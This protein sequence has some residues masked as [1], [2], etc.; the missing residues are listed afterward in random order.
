MIVPF[1][2]TEIKNEYT[3]EVRKELY[4]YKSSY[5]LKRRHI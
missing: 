1:Q 2:K 5:V 4:L 3:S